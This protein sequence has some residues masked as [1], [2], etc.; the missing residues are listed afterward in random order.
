LFARIGTTYG[1]GDGTTTFNLPNL[2]GR[3]PV[4]L[5][6]S[7]TEFDALAETGGTK[8]VTLDA[9]QIPSHTHPITDPGHAHTFTTDSSG[10]S[11]GWGGVSSAVRSAG[12]AYTAYP[13]TSSATT[14]I[15]VNGQSGT[16]GQAHNNLQP[17]IVMN[18]LIRIL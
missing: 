9:T 5:D 2:K 17:Y 8:T 15:T 4:G 13:A 6:S 7:Q 12:Y 16:I 3:V 10:G 1:V 14:S 18:Y 11:S